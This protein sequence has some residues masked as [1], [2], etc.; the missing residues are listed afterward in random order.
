MEKIEIRERLTNPKRFM[1]DI[2][3]LPTEVIDGEEYRVRVHEYSTVNNGSCQCFKDCDCSELKGKVTSHRN[4]WYR[5]IRF[6][7]TDKCFYSKPYTPPS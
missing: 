2:E 7:G 4:V 5:N 3:S 1:K 6:D